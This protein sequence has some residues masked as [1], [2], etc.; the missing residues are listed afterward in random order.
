VCEHGTSCR[1]GDRRCLSDDDCSTA[2]EKD[3]RNRDCTPMHHVR[4]RRCD[5]SSVCQP[6]TSCRR[7]DTRCLSDE[8]CDHANEQDG[9]R[10]DCSPLTG[11]ARSRFHRC[12]ESSVCE[13]GTSCRRGDRRCLT[14]DDCN[15]ANEKD[16]TRRDCTPLTG[17]SRSR[18][19]RCDES[20]EC[21]HGTSCRVGD[22]RCLTDEDC[23]RANEKDGRNRDCTPMHHVR[24]RRCDESSV[25]QPGTSCRRGDTRCLSDEDCAHANAADGTN[26]DCTPLSV[27]LR[28]QRCNEDTV[29]EPGSLCRRGDT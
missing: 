2:N 16:G 17:T 15:R 19:H 22:R 11:T 14:D 27:R 9:T 20:S 21:E 28:Y 29:C 18:F 7:G 1:R 23:S 10:R 4:F 25:C 6:G 3:G 8:D 13:V 24:F 12:D 5:A 26:R